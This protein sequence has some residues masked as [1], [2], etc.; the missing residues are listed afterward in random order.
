MN[1]L[2]GPNNCGKSTIINAFRVLEIGIRQAKSK[3]PVLVQGPNGTCYGYPLKSELIPMSLENVHTDLSY[4]ETSV[5]FKLSN[6]NKLTLFFPTTGGCVLLTNN[7]TT[8]LHSLSVFKREFPIS[9]H[10]VPVLGPVEHQEEIV[11]EETVKRSL[12]SHRASRHFRNYWRYFP[13]G[14][15]EF[16]ELVR[17]TWPGMEIQPPLRASSINDKL[18]MWCLENRITR[19]IFWAGFGFQ[20]WCQLLTHISRAK[21]ATVL[22]V[23]EPEIY[24]HP[25]IQRQL[26]G[27][28]RSAGP[29][30]IIATHSAEI[31]G[32]ADAS[33]IML[34][35][36]QKQS[37]ERLRD[38]DGVQ[39]ALESIGSIQNLTLT[40]L[41]RTRR[42]LFVEGTN[43]FKILRRFAKRLGL[44]ELSTG[45]DLTVVI[46][47]GF[48]AWEKIKSL[49]WGFKD[50][51]RTPINVGAVFD[52]DYWS[53]EEL[54]AIRLE[55]SQ[56]LTFSHIHVRK[57][58]ENYLLE[59][60]V[61]E[62]AYEKAL[63]ERSKTSQIDINEPEPLVAILDRITMPLKSKLQAQYIDK[64]TK[65]LKHIRDD[66]S[67]I[68]TE[69]I[70]LFNSKWDDIKTRMEIVAGKEVLKLLRS[71]LQQKYCVNLTD[72]RIIDEFSREEIPFSI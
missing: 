17:N 53:A 3:K 70:D 31:M 65:Y 5:I 21:D 35:D 8:A 32:E 61:L 29:E 64:R 22:V 18:V 19:E 6:G 20:I 72:N 43:D 60:N 10:I 47:G 40:Q 34:I 45:N 14:F 59:V 11:E 13:D 12:S 63:L 28:L 71:E 1:I 54:S 44:S 66:G 15:D 69:T 4:L 25:D 9:I 24:L 26:L 2:V 56:H 37:A 62:R 41:A 57:E 67:T 16:A 55:L 36:K 30:I 7:I 46:S 23:D 38:V 49:A 68:T 52:S 48:S 58:I 50:A 27:I 51:L 33:E 39:T 42:L